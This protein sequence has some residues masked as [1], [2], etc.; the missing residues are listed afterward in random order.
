M[1]KRLDFTACPPLRIPPTPS[2][3]GGKPKRRHLLEKPTFLFFFAAKKKEKFAKEK[4]NGSIRNREIIV[5]VF[6]LNNS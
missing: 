1:L 3:A 5:R 4:R 2:R 6:N